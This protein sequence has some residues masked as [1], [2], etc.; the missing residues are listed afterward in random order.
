MR[1]IWYAIAYITWI[2]HARLRNRCVGRPHMQSDISF[3]WTFHSRKENTVV[4][5]D[6]HTAQLIQIL[7]ADK[8]MLF[9]D[10]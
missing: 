2:C 10:E 9:I 3:E 8:N 6:T 1:D 5:D 7:C 4:K